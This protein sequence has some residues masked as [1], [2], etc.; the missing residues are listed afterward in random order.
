MLIKNGISIVKENAS[1]ALATLVEKVGEKFLPYFTETL[2]FLTGFLTE[3]SAPEYQQ[4]RGQ[5][6][7][8]I[9][10]ICASVGV[11]AFKPVAADVINVMLQI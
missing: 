1:T 8:A 2:Q 5:V 4:F 11:E 10:I 7:E 6:I 3:F 9:T